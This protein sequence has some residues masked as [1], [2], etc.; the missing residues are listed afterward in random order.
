M[1]GVVSPDVL[2]YSEVKN[3]QVDLLNQ[4]FAFVK[5]MEREAI[6]PRS[7]AAARARSL[8]TMRHSEPKGILY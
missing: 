8:I 7:E 3:Q 2:L 4:Y 1:R 5:S 6:V